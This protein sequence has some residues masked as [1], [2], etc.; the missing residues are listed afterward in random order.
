MI[1]ILGHIV[2]GVLATL[3]FSLLVRLCAR[4]SKFKRLAVLSV[5]VTIF[6]IIGALIIR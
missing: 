3:S 5:G 1:W 2:L 4:L 6:I